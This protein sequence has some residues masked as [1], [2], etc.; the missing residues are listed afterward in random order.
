MEPALSG[1]L[2]IKRELVIITKYK[3]NDKLLLKLRSQNKD[4]IRVCC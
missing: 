3:F 1:L 4:K 2:G